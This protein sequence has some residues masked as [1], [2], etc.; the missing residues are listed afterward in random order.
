MNV[1][2]WIF[3][4]VIVMSLLL[5]ASVGALADDIAIT[6][7]A[8]G[9]TVSY[10]FRDI[11]FTSPAGTKAVIFLDGSKLTEF[12]SAGSNTFSLD[13][14]LAIGN[15]RLEIIAA[16]GTD[17]VSAESRFS[18]S[19]SVYTQKSLEKFSSSLGTFTV[20]K[21]KTEVNLGLDAD[22]KDVIME[23]V[24]NLEGADGSASGAAGYYTS[25]SLGSGDPT[26]NDG[27]MN[28]T[29]TGWESKVYVVQYDLKLFSG[30][31]R[32]FLEAQ[33]SDGKTVYIGSPENKKSDFFVQS[34]TVSATG[35]SYPVGEWM[36]V[37]HTLD[38]INGT[39]KHE[40]TFDGGSISYTTSNALIK[41][42]TYLRPTY[43]YQRKNS[44]GPLGFALDNFEIGV[45][46]SYSPYSQLY[47][48]EQSGDYV[49]AENN[50]ITKKTRS[51]RLACAN[52]CLSNGGV[53]DSVKVIVNG[54]EFPV[55]SASVTS[56]G[57]YLDIEFEI[58]LPSLAE[59]EIIFSS[60]ENSAD[61]KNLNYHSC[62][63][64]NYM[65][66]GIKDILYSGSD[67]SGNYMMKSQLEAGGT[68]K[69]TVD[70][71]NL[72]ESEQ[73]ALLVTA[74]YS[75]NKI[76]SLLANEATVPAGKST[77]A[78]PVSVSLPATGADFNIETY[79]FDG[80][81][82]RLPLSIIWSLK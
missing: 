27:Y 7:P 3:S 71:V 65:D 82:H 62:F 63:D 32:F 25:K 77:Y 36:H 21:S 52:P 56:D 1:K 35:E 68:L 20:A 28:L 73:T 39:Q 6:S 69:L 22:G 11:V 61:E 29:L 15:H 59:A 78:V 34:G 44:T 42:L 23:S 19:K 54:S 76:A 64:V 12:I 50:E 38:T 58:D 26:G 4:A 13:S 8:D 10:T 80:F 40:I 37:K 72:G 14:E 55:A 51:V 53:T 70:F 9:E 33:N 48:K 18:V 75:G 60:A 41:S 81:L 31:A 43:Y 47:Y 45:V 57:A 17:A 74:V 66:F 30:K 67:G 24:T 16:D 5:A 79:L 2:K 46:D 49:L